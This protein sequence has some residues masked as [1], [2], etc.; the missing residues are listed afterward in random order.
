MHRKPPFT[1]GE[2]L[3]G[4]RLEREKRAGIDHYVPGQLQARLD[5]EEPTVGFVGFVN[6]AGQAVLAICEWG[7]GRWE[8]RIVFRSGVMVCTSPMHAN[9]IEF[10]LNDGMKEA[11]NKAKEEA[12][13]SRNQ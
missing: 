6:G 11:L 4:R 9:L 13:A 7:G 5:E 12:N 2:A 10:T 8:P 3:L 1:L